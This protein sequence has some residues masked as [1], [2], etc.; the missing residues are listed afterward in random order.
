MEWW[1]DETC[2][3]HTMNSGFTWNY[4]VLFLRRTQTKHNVEFFFKVTAT[5]DVELMSL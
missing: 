1:G 5:A 3:F 4:F 2:Y